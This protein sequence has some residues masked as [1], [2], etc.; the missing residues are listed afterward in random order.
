MACR[1]RI[2]KGSALPGFTIGL[3]AEPPFCVFSLAKSP[4]IRYSIP[5]KTKGNEHDQ[6]IYAHRMAIGR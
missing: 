1:I 4:R 2:D 3:N 5:I 6:P